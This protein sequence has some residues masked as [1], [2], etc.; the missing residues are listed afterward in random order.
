[1]DSNLVIVRLAPAWEDHVVREALNTLPD[2]LA[3]QAPDAVIY[4][5]RNVLTRVKIGGYDVVAKAFP[6]AQTVLKRLQR[7]GRTSKAVR[8]FDHDRRM[9]DLGI[10]TPE[11]FAVIEAT[12]GRAWYLC[13]WIADCATVR[14]LDQRD[15]DEAEK[16]CHDLG[17]FI[18]QMHHLGVY[19]FDST[20][21]N[22][23]LRQVNNQSHFLVVDCN[24]M[25]FGRIGVW[26]GL[27][28]LVQLE[29]RGRLLTGYCQARSW[30]VARVKRTYQ[31][32]LW[33]DRMILRMK[34][35]T[36]PLR[37]KLGL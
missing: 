13:A 28:S 31:L 36:R 27:R 25:R 19:H 17:H 32:R 22:I 37:R 15:G 7:F 12:D 35:F 24:R 5:G 9:L 20:P 1:M 11:P 14:Y 2:L 30:D 4:A 34:K 29:T 33:C 26:A 18:G 3:R 10:G 6:A 16:L 21:G 8:A 23:L